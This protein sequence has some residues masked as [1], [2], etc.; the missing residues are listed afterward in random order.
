MR[1]TGRLRQPD[2]RCE[3]AHPDRLIAGDR[4]EHL[5][6]AKDTFQVEIGSTA[7]RAGAAPGHASTRRSRR[8]ACRSGNS[9]PIVLPIDMPTS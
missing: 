8:S 3:L 5:K 6:R 7:L 2:D 4:L 9:M 1:C